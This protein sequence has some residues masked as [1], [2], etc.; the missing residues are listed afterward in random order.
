MEVQNTKRVVCLDAHAAEIKCLKRLQRVVVFDSLLRPRLFQNSELQ[1][2]PEPRQA[3]D[4]AL[5]GA[6]EA[7]P[8]AVHQHAAAQEDA[9]AALGGRL[10]G[11]GE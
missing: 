6:H 2:R 7:R 11:E 5:H 3:L 8:H 9:D 10:R 4:P 1:L